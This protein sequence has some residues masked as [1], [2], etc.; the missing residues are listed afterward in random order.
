MEY[1]KN[2]IH[3]QYQ[4]SKTMTCR[5]QKIKELQKKWRECILK[6]DELTRELWKIETLEK[7]I[8]KKLCEYGEQD[9]QPMVGET[10][11]LD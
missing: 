5:E 10:T 7:E 1:K 9:F 8:T 6:K 2:Y 3:S 4:I 11:D